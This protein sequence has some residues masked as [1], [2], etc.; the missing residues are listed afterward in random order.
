MAYVA[1]LAAIGQLA[2]CF[3]VAFSVFYVVSGLEDYLLHRL[4]VGLGVVYCS[5]KHLFGLIP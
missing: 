2:V 1:I 3:V 5:R 4:D